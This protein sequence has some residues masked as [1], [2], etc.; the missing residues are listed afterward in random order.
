MAKSKKLVF[1]TTGETYTYQALRGEGKNGTVYEVVDSQGQRWALKCLKPDQ[2][3]AKQTKRFLN[4]LAFCQKSPHA[5]VVTVC[6]CGFIVMK[7]KKCPFYV[8]P[9][10]PSTLRHL[11]RSGV[12]PDAVLPYFSQILDGVEA[13]HI[14]DVW[15]RDLKP[16]NILHAPASKVLVVSDFGVAHFAEEAMRTTVETQANERLANFQYSAPEQ[17]ARGAKVDHRADIFALGLILN[18]MFTGEVPQGT[19]FR[20]IGD[21][22]SEYAYLDEI[23]DRMVRQSPVDRLESIDG[24]K[25][26]LIG[27]RNEFISRQKLHVLRKR[28]VPSGVVVDPMVDNPVQVTSVDVAGSTLVVFLN[29]AVRPQWIRAFKSIGSY[30]SMDGSAPA[31]WDFSGEQASVRLAQHILDTYFQRVID[32]FKNYVQQANKDY[33]ANLEQAARLTEENERRALQQQ[34]EQ[35]ERRQRIL[36]SVK[37]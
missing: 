36:S 2:A 9:L 19:G 12:A 1:E 14:Q 15:H 16:E 33:S 26:I 8:M 18:E 28:V 6:D 25:Q 35:E 10:Y 13:A 30:S 27:K 7:G 37:I 21:V 24:I 17:R 29:Q 3:T 32:H 11:L 22:A 5:N 34:V 23:V 4:E 31:N 20:K